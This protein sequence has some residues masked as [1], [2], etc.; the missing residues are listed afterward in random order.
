MEATNRI[1][2]ETGYQGDYMMGPSRYMTFTEQVPAQAQ[3]M[4]S[5]QP[6]EGYMNYPVY[7]PQQ[8]APAPYNPGYG[9]TQHAP[10]GNPGYFQ[11]SMAAANMVGPPPQ[12]HELSKTN[13]Y[14]SSL[15]VSTSDNDLK[16]LCQSYGAIVSA[17]AIIDRATG[18][19]KG[20]GFVM[21]EREASAAA[22]IDGLRLMGIGADYARISRAQLELQGKIPVDPTNLYIANIPQ[23][24]DE[25]RLTELLW[26][27]MNGQGEVLSCRVLRDEYAQSRGVALSRLDSEESCKLVISSLNGHQ[28]EGAIE[29]LRVKHANCPQAR[30]YKFLQQR[31]PRM[32]QPTFYPGQGDGMAEYSESVVGHAPMSR[33]GSSEAGIHQGQRGQHSN[34]ASP[35]ASGEASATASPPAQATAA[36]PQQRLS[37]VDPRTAAAHG[38]LLR[39]KQVD[40]VST[41]AGHGSSFPPFGRGRQ[42]AGRSRSTSEGLEVPTHELRPNSAPDSREADTLASRMNVLS[43]KDEFPMPE[44]AS[45]WS[46]QRNNDSGVQDEEAASPTL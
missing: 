10:Q 26:Q 25:T 31:A 15:K 24:M 4:Y 32:S 42:A 29:P 13:V 40:A 43:M 9:M 11:P 19:C 7:A 37:D 46:A 22:A 35:V 5:P 12:Q 44:K 20:Y 30:R 18:L 16:V 27:V 36:R 41:F 3:T 17:K 8:A 1:M 21:F 34:Q 28:L 6:A 23:T 33:E 38:Q 14:I 39:Q 45:L 2:L